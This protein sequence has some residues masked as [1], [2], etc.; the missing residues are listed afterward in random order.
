[1]RPYRSGRKS[2]SPIEATLLGLLDIK[3]EFADDLTET[4]G[5]FT[6]SGLKH[7]SAARETDNG[8]EIEQI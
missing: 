8:A 6:Q 7:S 1:M 4:K 2:V 3:R 5:L